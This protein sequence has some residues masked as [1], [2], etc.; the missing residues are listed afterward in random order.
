MASS[1]LSSAVPETTDGLQAREDLIA[2]SDED[3][4]NKAI[5]LCAGLR[6]VRG[7]RGRG[8]GRLMELRKLL[9]EHR[10][11]SQLFNTRRWVRD[12]EEAYWKVW[13]KWE[14]GE[15]DDIRM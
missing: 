4:E 5:R 15:D 6:Y 1:I 9:I 2:R 10:W 3:Y 12:L 7:G 8:E 14:N 11:D 13:K